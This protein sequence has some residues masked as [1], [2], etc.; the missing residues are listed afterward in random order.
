MSG[1]LLAIS[2]GPVQEFIAAARR[3]RDLWFGSYLLSEI[4]KAAAKSLYESGT[5]LIFPAPVTFDQL[6]QGSSFNA[7]N[8]LLASVPVEKDTAAIADAAY[9][10]AQKRWL[11]FADHTYRQWGAEVINDRIWC[12]QL[13]DII[14]FYAA[15]VPYHENYRHARIRVERLLAG[16]KALRDFIP[17]KGFAGVP[18]SSLDGARE[19]VLQRVVHKNPE[20][21]LAL[22][23][24][25]GEH[26]D[27][28]GLV[29]RTAKVDFA[30]EKVNF[31]SVTRVAADSWIRG[32]SAAPAGRRLFEELALLCRD[33]FAPRISAPQYSAF[34]F[35]CDILYP[36]RMQA[37]MKEPYLAE[38]NDLFG[39]IRT[40]LKYFRDQYKV[41]E[42]SP[43]FAVLKA[44]GDKMGSFLSK[45]STPDE[46]RNFSLA[47]SEFALNAKS[48]V[49]RHQGC[50]VYSGGDDVLAFLPVDTGIDAARQLRD[51]FS[52]RL[53]RE[54]T[55]SVGIAMG[56]CME[57]LEDHLR[58]AGETEKNAKS[59]SRDD[60]MDERNGL[61][62]LYWTRGGG[63]IALRDQWCNNP[64]LRLGRWSRLFME[65]LLPDKAAYDLRRLA[66]DYAFW[67][68]EKLPLRLLQQDAKR[69]L[70]KKEAGGKGLASAT[71]DELLESIH[72]RDSLMVL[73]SELLMARQLAVGKRMAS[74]LKM[75]GEVAR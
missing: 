47:L 27:A 25:R 34:P 72:N 52:N 4:S 3:T 12:S 36:S 26:L 57:P 32:V 23:I 61:A 62:L 29:K 9:E 46:H 55:L 48:I 37:L 17:A 20:Q 74:R 8:K 60:R 67:P 38:Y 14:E 40:K 6:E 63:P 2:L 16:R 18:K 70:L 45:M 31:V 50:L 49:E 7:A 66:G 11:A 1:H 15:W 71:I 35:E 68:D 75:S 42:P 64:D 43:Y 51:E 22:R 54:A 24:K 30:E 28:V 19:S 73:A 44:D 5:T 21:C 59:G 39:Q 58:L 10:A 53:G 56:H 65:D 33:A 41:G 69:L 13:K